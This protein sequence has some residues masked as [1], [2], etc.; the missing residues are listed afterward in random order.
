MFLLHIRSPKTKDQYIQKFEHFFK[1]LSQQ[2][3]EK[4]FETEDIEKK[5]L[6]LYDKA[7]S[8][9]WLFNCILKYVHFINKRVETE[10]LSGATFYNYFKNIKKFCLANDIEVK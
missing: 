10:N 6:L 3:E 8:E 2:L 4:E 7:K 5:Y 1:F 9:H